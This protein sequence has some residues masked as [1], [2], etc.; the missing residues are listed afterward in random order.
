MLVESFEVKELYN[1][2][3]NRAS[4]QDHCELPTKGT[5]QVKNITHELSMRYKIYTAS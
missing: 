4:I 3:S 2:Q 5:F 1:D